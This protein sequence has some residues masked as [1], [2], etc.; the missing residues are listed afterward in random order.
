[1]EFLEK[2][3]HMISDMEKELEKVRRARTQPG[4][5]TQFVTY[6]INEIIK[7]RSKREAGEPVKI[8]GYALGKVGELIDKSFE[9][10]DNI[11]KNIIVTIQAYV[12]VKE[13]FIAHENEKKQAS[14]VETSPASDDT[15]S[16]IR[17]VGQRPE[18]KIAERKKKKTLTKES[19]SKKKAQK[20]KK[21]TK[22]KEE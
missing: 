4:E 1:M 15:P 3:D 17:K 8:L 10:L 5:H 12:R 11:E 14:Q 6:E 18:N 19:N 9:R 7:D 21:T 16:G 20:K 22:A 2:I 13:S